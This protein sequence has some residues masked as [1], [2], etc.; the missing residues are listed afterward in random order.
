[1]KGRTDGQNVQLPDARGVRG[2][3]A[4]IWCGVSWHQ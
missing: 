1:V 3:R 2:A 4:V